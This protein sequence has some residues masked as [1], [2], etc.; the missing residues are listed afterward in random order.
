VVPDARLQ[1][2]TA[3]IHRRAYGCAVHVH[4]ARRVTYQ[5]LLGAPAKQTDR[6]LADLVYVC[7]V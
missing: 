6:P 3:D 4:S 1:G 5:A 2:D 7:E